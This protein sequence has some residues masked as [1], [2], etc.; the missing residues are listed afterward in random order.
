[1]G[2]LE[3]LPDR[4]GADPRGT[5]SLDRSA[6]GSIRLKEMLEEDVEQITQELDEEI[7]E[8]LIRGLSLPFSIELPHFTY[9]RRIVYSLS[10]EEM[11]YD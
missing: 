6:R 7:R 11:C 10:G 9:D 8:R 3:N 4:L 2:V 5:W 1:M